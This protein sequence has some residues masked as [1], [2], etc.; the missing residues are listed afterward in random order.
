MAL[1][2]SKENM[3]LFEA[4]K[5]SIEEYNLKLREE[6]ESAAERLEGAWVE[7]VRQSSETGQLY[8]SVTARDI[9]DVLTEKYFKI[10]RSSVTLSFPIKLTGV[11][12]ISLVL[13]PDVFSDITL[14]VGRSA[15]EVQNLSASFLALREKD[16]APVDGIEEGLLASS[17]NAEDTPEKAS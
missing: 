1:R 5:A 14:I 17:P 7:L 2:A 8:G 15:D 9:A 12:T 11:H 10:D 16:K 4:R 13:H 3:K 6:A